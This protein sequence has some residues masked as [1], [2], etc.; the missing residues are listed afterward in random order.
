MGVHYIIT[1]TEYL[2]RWA[3]AQLVKDFMVVTVAKF[4][5]ENILTR[6]GYPKILMRDRGTYFLNEII[7]TLTKEFQIYHQ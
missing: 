1:L 7:S 4:L 6:F 5:F 2:T 3:E